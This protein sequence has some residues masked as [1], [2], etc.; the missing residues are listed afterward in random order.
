MKQMKDNK[1]YLELA[2]EVEENPL[3]PVGLVL[4]LGSEVSQLVDQLH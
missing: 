2:R 1:E 4:H 3:L